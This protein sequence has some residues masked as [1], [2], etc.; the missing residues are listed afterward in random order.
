MEAWG[1]KVKYALPMDKIFKHS[2]KPPKVTVVAF[3]VENGLQESPIIPLSGALLDSFGS[4]TWNGSTT[5]S[6]TTH[7]GNDEWS[8]GSSFSSNSSFGSDTWNN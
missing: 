5:S 1:R 8:G 2:Y 4:D 3:K 6:S 7:F